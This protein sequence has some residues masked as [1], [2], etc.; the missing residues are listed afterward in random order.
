M[1]ITARI[2]SLKNLKFTEISK[3]NVKAELKLVDHGL[4]CY[5]LSYFI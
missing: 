4:I 3:T 5:M 1:V 2:I